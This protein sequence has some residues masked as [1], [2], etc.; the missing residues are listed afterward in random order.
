MPPSGRGET[1]SSGQ[2]AVRCS[3]VGSVVD[4]RRGQRLTS[5]TNS[6]RPSSWAAGA[7]SWSARP[8]GRPRREATEGGSSALAHA[9]RATIRAKQAWVRKTLMNGPLATISPTGRKGRARR[10]SGQDVA[11]GVNALALSARVELAV[12]GEAALAVD[13]GRGLGGAAPGGREE[14]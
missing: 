10:N 7:R 9:L 8:A 13:L 14:H 5:I 11:G 2:K 6:L 4:S 3:P 12:N 1:W